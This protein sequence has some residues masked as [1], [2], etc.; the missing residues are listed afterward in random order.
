MF[1][2]VDV[3]TSAVKATLIDERGRIEGSASQALRLSTPRPGWAEQRPQDWWRGAAVAIQ[4]ALRAAKLPAAGVAAVGL[5]GQMHSSVFLDARNAVIRPA[6][7]WCD[8]RTTEECREITARVGE[9]QLARWVQNPALEGFTLPKVLWLRRHEPAAFERLAKVVL[10]KDYVRLRLTGALASEP[11][12]ASATL[13]Y[14]GA[15][16]RWSQPLLRAL[17]LPPALLPDVGASTEVL[18]T[19]TSEAGKLT[20]LVAGTPVVG[21]GADN[22]CGAVGVGLVAPGEAV[23]SWG[24]SGT[25]LTPTAEPR[26]DP[27]MRAHTFCHVAPDTWY[28]MGVMLTAGGAFAWFARE[29]A[30]DLRRDVELA[31][32]R[33][34]AR[35]PPGALGLT[36]LPYLQGERTPH[37]DAAARGAFVGL[38]LAHGRAHLARAVAEGICFGLRDSLEIL[39]GLAPGLDRVLVTGGGA[40]SPFVRRLQADVYGLPVVRVNRE[41][42][43][44]FGAALLAAV[45]VGAFPDLRAAAAATL[46]RLAAEAPDRARHEAY[47]APYARFRAL[48]PALRAVS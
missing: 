5:S 2:G 45:G 31:L 34:A 26:V 44:A 43:P 47:S 48:Y 18:G 27:G 15:A 38:S 11:S 40:R 36:F 10:A 12:D 17:E 42:G 4:G 19:V 41:E 28:L 46:K 37:R 32:N 35:V 20:G 24:T 6:L 33:E 25:V 22:A 14:D 16:R 21:G 29:L 9:A 23:A 3:G 8:G 7:L 39:R 13:M 1:L 30:R